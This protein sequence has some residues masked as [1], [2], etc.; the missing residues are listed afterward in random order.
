MIASWGLVEVPR[1]LFYALNLLDRV[2]SWLFFLRYHF[3]MILY[4]SGFVAEIA[5]MTMALQDLQATDQV[6][7]SHSY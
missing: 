6:R 1:Y 3:F 4:P 2:P 5:C 7:V